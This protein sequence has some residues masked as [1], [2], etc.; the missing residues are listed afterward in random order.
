MQAKGRQ[1]RD[2]WIDGLYIIFL[3]FS[4]FS[5]LS[6]FAAI[7]ECLSLFHKKPSE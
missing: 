3:F 6:L 5:F 2:E 1:E 4:F 7:A